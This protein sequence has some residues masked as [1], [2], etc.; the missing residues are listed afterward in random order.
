[1]ILGTTIFKMGGEDYY[2]PPFGRGGNA[3]MFSM[4]VTHVTATPSVT[5]TVE[6]KN[7]DDTAWTG[8]GGFAAITG[9]GVSTKDLS[10]LKQQIRFK[11]AFDAGDAADA[12][13]HF[14]MPAPA[15]RPN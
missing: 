12:G 10:G 9:V 2:S 1:M 15:W 11:F 13:I 3:A 14:M 4:D 6:H 7:T 5:V 8:A